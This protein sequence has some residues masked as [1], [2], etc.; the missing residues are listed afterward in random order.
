MGTLT[1]EPGENALPYFFLDVIF[2]ISEAQRAAKLRRSFRT[3]FH[4]VP[5]RYQVF[6]KKHMLSYTRISCI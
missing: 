6:G 5:V 2:R 4:V 3:E 1:A